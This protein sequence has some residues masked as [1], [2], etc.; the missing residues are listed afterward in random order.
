MRKKENK[1]NSLRDIWITVKSSDIRITGI[2]GNEKRIKG[3]GK[4]L[5]R[6]W[7]KIFQ[8]LNQKS[9]SKTKR[10][11]SKAPIISNGQ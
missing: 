4:Y 7:P 8:K 11:I 10:K 1:Y 9:K 3:Q 5:K 6:H 2:L